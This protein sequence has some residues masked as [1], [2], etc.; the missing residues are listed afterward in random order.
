LAKSLAKDQSGLTV[1]TA[2][3]LAGGY[4][5]RANRDHVFVTRKDSEVETDYG[6]DRNVT[7]LPIDVV[8]VPER[9]F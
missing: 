8:R 9:Y 4:T 1:R 7:I 2:I 6:K 3:A 5:Y